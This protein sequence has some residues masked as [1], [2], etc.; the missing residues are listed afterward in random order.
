MGVQSGEDLFRWPS[1]SDIAT[2]VNDASDGFGN[3]SNEW[4]E[5]ARRFGLQAKKVNTGAGGCY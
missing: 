3:L 5:L 2:V 4:G 1:T